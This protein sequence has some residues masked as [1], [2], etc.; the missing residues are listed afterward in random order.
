MWELSSF[1]EAAIGSPRCTWCTAAPASQ[2]R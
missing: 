2:P 1:S